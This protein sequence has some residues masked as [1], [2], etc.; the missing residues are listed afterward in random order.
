MPNRNNEPT[1]AELAALAAGLLP[2]DRTRVGDGIYMTID[3]QGRQ[4]FQWRARMGGRGSRQAGGTEC[5]FG[6]AQYARDRFLGRKTNGVLKRL[7]RGRKMSIDQYV[8][9]VWLPEV[10]ETTEPNTQVNYER[11]WRIDIRPYW[12]GVTFEELL[13]RESF[14][15]FSRHLEKTKKHKRDN[16]YICVTVGTSRRSTIP[17]MRLPSPPSF[18]QSG[19][20]LALA[21]LAAATAASGVCAA[22]TGAAAHS[23]V[24]TAADVRATAAFQGATGS[25]FGGVTVTNRSKT[26]CSLPAGARVQLSWRRWRLAVRST[27]FPTNWLARM[28]PKW[29]TAVRTLPP[30]G[31]AQV[32]LQ[33]LNWCGRTPWGV[34]HAFHLTVRVRL[35]DQHEPVTATTQDLVLPPTCNQTPQAGTGSTLRVSAFVGMP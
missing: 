33:W 29:K 22:S 14:Q 15:D 8:A 30:H 31:R 10:F 13:E 3:R 4:R 19:S 34:H 26:K 23:R 35:P 18:T 17:K 7:E 12:T 25:D 24:C 11:V 28:N 5:S 27:P 20:R 1:K 6:D 2:G 21:A 9:K 16:P 32:I